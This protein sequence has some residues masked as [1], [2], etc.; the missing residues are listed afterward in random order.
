MRDLE[1]D[2]QDLPTVFIIDDVQ[3]GDR[4]VQE[5]LSAMVIVLESISDVSL[6]CTSREI[7]CSTRVRP[8]SRGRSRR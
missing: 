1:M 8:S 7:P 4:T 3:K 5:F 6:I 2:L